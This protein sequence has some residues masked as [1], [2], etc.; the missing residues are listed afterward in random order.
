MSVSK[1]NFWAMASYFEA[2][3]R[4]LF[5]DYYGYVDKVFGKGCYFVSMRI[6]DVS[7]FCTAPIYG[8]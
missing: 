4:Y 1:L 2:Y 6:G 7:C 3:F 8:L 5:E